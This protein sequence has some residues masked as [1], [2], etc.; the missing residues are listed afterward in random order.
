MK[1]AQNLKALSED[2]GLIFSTCMAPD[3]HLECRNTCKQN[4]LKIKLKIIKLT[5]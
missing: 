5:S 4:T 1:M 2:L 3:T